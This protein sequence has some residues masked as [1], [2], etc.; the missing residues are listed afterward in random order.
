M[1]TEIKGAPAFAHLAVVLEPGERVIAESGAMSSMDAGLELKA[2][3]N[4]NPFSALMRK[5]LGGETFFLSAFGNSSSAEQRLVLAR[6]T[7]GDIREVSLNNDECFY[8]QAG[9]FL[10]CTDGIKIGLKWAGF[11]SF[12]AREG[13]FKIAVRGTGRVWY[14]AYGA[15]LEKDVDGDIIV[16]SGHLV[17][18][19]PGL[20]L[21]LRLAGGLFSSFFGGE[22]LVMRI[23]GKGRITLQTRSL[24]GLAGWLNPK[25]RG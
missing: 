12:L 3:I 6:T 2:R 18:Y 7:P 21:K 25:L 24:G 1:H 4:G 15:L 19:G 23:V 17:A 22:G 11:T 13:L 16:D 20:K 9:A 8:L 10:A 14:G 5:L